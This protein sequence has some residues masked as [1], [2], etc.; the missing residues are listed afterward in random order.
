MLFLALV[1]PFGLLAVARA[2]ERLAPQPGPATVPATALAA[3]L[4]APALTIVANQLSR[5][6]EVRADRFAME[7]TGD[8]GA[9]IEFQRRIAV[10]NVADPDPPAWV[11]VLFGTHPTTMERIGLALAVGP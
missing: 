3:E 10:Q 9:L 5:G 8:S 2:A 1:A 7:L 4:L 11:R 6:V